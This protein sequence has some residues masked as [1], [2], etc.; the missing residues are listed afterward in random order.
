MKVTVKV[1]KTGDEIRLSAMTVEELASAKIGRRTKAL[2]VRLAKGSD[3]SD[4][5]SIAQRLKT[6]PGNERGQIYLEMQTKCGEIV[7]IQLPET[8]STNLAAR[9]ALKDASG[10]EQ[11]VDGESIAA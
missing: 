3:P 8:Y 5:A 2:R 7:V 4:I 9:Q 10:V 6:I 11:V 1:R